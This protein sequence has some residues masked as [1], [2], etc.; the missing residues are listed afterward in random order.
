MKRENSNT[1]FSVPGDEG[2]EEA[3][4][5]ADGRAAEGHKK[6][7]GDP[8]GDVNGLDV[9]LA[10]LAEALEQVIQD[11]AGRERERGCGANCHI[12]LIRPRA[13]ELFNIQSFSFPHVFSSQSHSHSF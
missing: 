11:L 4:D 7:G 10:E 5:D 3:P 13:C 1:L 6:E 12:R 8:A 9:V 2:G